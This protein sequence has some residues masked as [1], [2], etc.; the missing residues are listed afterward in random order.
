MNWCET[1]STMN[2]KIRNHRE[3][4]SVRGQFSIRQ[5]PRLEIA[6]IISITDSLTEIEKGKKLIDEGPPGNSQTEQPTKNRIHFSGR[7]G[8]LDFFFKVKIDDSFQISFLEMF[9]STH[10]WILSE[11]KS[12]QHLLEPIKQ[13][14]R[15]KYRYRFRPE[16]N[17]RTPDISLFQDPCLKKKG[18]VNYLPQKTHGDTSLIVLES[19]VSIFFRAG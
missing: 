9:Y 5:C 6:G 18:A 12:S 15:R 4:T 7:V 17:L 3:T 16:K 14:I 10:K 19:R 11:K 1:N 13:P 2:K 8:Q